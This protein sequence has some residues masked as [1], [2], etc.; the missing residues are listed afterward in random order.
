MC[1]NKS[2]YIL[3]FPPSFPEEWM[4]FGCSEGLLEKK[5]EELRRLRVDV[6]L[7]FPIGWFRRTQYITSISLFFNK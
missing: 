4:V 2:F 6:S 1:I 3:C 7:G 5:E